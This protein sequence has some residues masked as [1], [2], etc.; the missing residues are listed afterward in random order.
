MKDPRSSQSKPKKGR[1]EKI[2][3]PRR[4]QITIETSTYKRLKHIAVERD[5]M[6]VSV[7]VEE[8][9][10]EWLERQTGEGTKS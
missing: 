4:L 8:A 1:I 2:K 9:L 10:Q 6:G 5:L 7:L 3:S